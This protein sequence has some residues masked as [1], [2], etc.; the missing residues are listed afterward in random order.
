MCGPRNQLPSGPRLAMRC[1]QIRLRGLDRSQTHRP[2]GER[3]RRAVSRLP[4]RA[5]SKRYHLAPP[6][7]EWA[8]GK[9]QISRRPPHRRPACDFPCL[10]GAT[11][12]WLITP[13]HFWPPPARRQSSVG[14]A[15][16]CRL[17]SCG[18]WARESPRSHLRTKD[19]PRRQ[20]EV[21]HRPTATSRDI[22][23]RGRAS[24][25]HRVML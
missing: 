10:I 23:Q 16:G 21:C 18:F 3:H 15:A 17:L 12:R 8:P 13:A 25:Q 5:A 9:L 20:A 24:K 11:R 7:Q 22:L 2:R 6:H 4:L 1:P 14:I 19:R